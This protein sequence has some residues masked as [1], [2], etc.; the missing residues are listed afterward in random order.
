MKKLQAGPLNLV[1]DN[2]FIRRISYGQTELLRMIYF[3]LRDHNWNTLPHHIE[4]E[5]LF[6]EDDQFRI[7]YD[8]NH[9]E[10]GVEIMEW[11]CTIE[12][13][14]DGGIV[15]EI[16]GRMKETFL[17]NRAG[18]CILHPLT[19]AGTICQI[20]HPG[21]TKT[22][23][24][25]PREISAENPYK[26]IQSMTWGGAGADFSLEFVGDIFE[27]EDQRNWADAS[28]KTFCTPLDKPFPVEMKRGQKVHQRVTFRPTTLLTVNGDAPAFVT[29]KRTD[30]RAIL[31]ALGIACS[32][33]VSPLSDHHI[34]MLR[35]LS[36][37]HYRIDLY[38][39][40]GDFAR[41]F[42]DEYETAYSMGVALEVALHLTENFREEME[43]FMILCR[44][45]RVNLRKVLL[46]S[47]NVLVTSQIVIDNAKSLKDA[48]PRVLIGGGTNYN[49][50]EINKNRFYPGELD[51]IGFSVDPQE[52]A[53]DSLTI[54]EN[55]IGLDDLVRSTKAIY[56]DRLQ[57]HISPLTLRKRYNPYATD[58]ADLC[59]EESRKAD[60]RQ[61]DGLGALWTF[62][63]IRSLT[64]G[65][66][67][68]VTCYQTAGN[69][70]VISA[71]GEP[72]PLYHVLRNFGAYQG[73][74]VQILES[75]EPLSVSAMI[76]DNKIL[77]LANLSGEAKVVL[78]GGTEYTLAADE[79]RFQLLDHP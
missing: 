52:H 19:V 71:E 24:E 35:A 38:P 67:L 72:Y 36:L 44:Q 33:E 16:T 25:F 1:Y 73:R 60:P 8:C 56:G 63:S 28:F 27:T 6:I 58:P 64:E 40:N 54:I 4:N 26:N 41:R 46:L 62:E 29:L 15:F 65:G 69:Q 53:S 74:P 59:I 11:K 7:A 42:S 9:T 77:A 17:K 61:K 55:A 37:S 57:V 21:G 30:R 76:L 3:A 75:S 22:R 18:F 51:Y 68:A 10:G 32:S 34:L 70:G 13:H 43:A 48:L 5:E 31:P 78:W 39:G 50:N 2:G 47:S 79:V 45:N 23:K 20:L 14:P 12:G 49:F 66:A